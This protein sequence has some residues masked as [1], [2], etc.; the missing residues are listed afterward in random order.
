MNARGGERAGCGDERTKQS[1][2]S[3][4]LWPQK[5]ST[6]DDCPSTDEE[7]ARRGE[8]RREQS[9]IPN[10]DHRG[11]HGAGSVRSPPSLFVRP[12]NE[13][14]A[15]A[16]GRRP[17]ARTDLV[18]PRSLV[19]L[20]RLGRAAVVRRPPRRCPS[21]PA[22]LGMRVVTTCGGSSGAFV[23]NGAGEL[24]S[25][26]LTPPWT[27]GRMPAAVEEEGED[28]RSGCGSLFHSP[29]RRR[30]SDRRVSLLRSS[31]S[32]P[33]SRFSSRC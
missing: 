29:R 3:Y 24:A 21:P 30:Q 13:R 20:S 14:T 11:R 16:D 12:P 27:T 28:Q 23:H 8:A 9:G 2:S 17:D 5:H 1:H 26:P 32:S 7:G 31:S 15:R 4:S 22:V 10:R 18:G 19:R 6:A 33:H 25:P